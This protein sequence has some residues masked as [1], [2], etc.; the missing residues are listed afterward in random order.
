MD[1]QEV[2]PQYH[3]LFYTHRGHFKDYERRRVFTPCNSDLSANASM[4]T[5]LLRESGEQ[6]TFRGGYPQP[7]RK[8]R[9]DN[10]VAG[11]RV[12][13]RIDCFAR[14]LNF[15]NDGPARQVHRLPCGQSL[16]TRRWRGRL[17][18]A[19]GGGGARDQRGA[20]DRCYGP[21][22][23][24]LASHSDTSAGSFNLREI[25]RRTAHGPSTTPFAGSRV[26]S[27]RGSDGVTQGNVGTRQDSG[28]RAATCV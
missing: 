3:F 12:Q 20:Q 4:S 11:T 13:N 22:M 16:D 2:S 25:R 6:H 26:T 21:K 24:E 10:R 23:G 1:I 19:G 17:G 5:D 8:G 27:K 18:Q 15:Q 14:D 9:V 7:L 28:S